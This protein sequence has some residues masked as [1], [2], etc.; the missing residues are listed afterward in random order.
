[1]VEIWSVLLYD[2]RKCHFALT[3]LHLIDL[4]YLLSSISP[5]SVLSD[6][7]YDHDS[8]AETE[9]PDRPEGQD[10]VF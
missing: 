8:A 2:E 3:F 6:I 7:E 9:V 10:V 4:C 5:A 1:M